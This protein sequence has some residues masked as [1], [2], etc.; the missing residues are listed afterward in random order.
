MRSRPNQRANERGAALLI[1]LLLVATMSF[2]A[3]AIS[4][5]TVLAATRSGN[6]RARGEILWIALGV[7][8]LA[9][10]ALIESAQ[11]E[12][13]MTPEH[14]LFAAPREIPF[15]GGGAVITFADRTRCFNV[16]AIGATN[17]EEDPG[18]QEFGALVD[19]I[20]N[21]PAGADRLG[22]AIRDWIDDDSLQEPGGAEDSYYA[23]LPAPYRTGG[24]PLGDVSEIRAIAGGELEIYA[25][26]RRFLCALPVRE[27]VKLNVNML[28]P[29]DAPLISAMTG[30]AVTAADAADVISQRPAGGYAAGGDFWA[31]PVF[32][33]NPLPAEVTGRA[34]ATSEYVEAYAVISVGDVAMN[35]SMLFQTGGGSARLVSRR[36]ER[37]E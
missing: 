25:A 33:A 6:V 5:R 21:L 9:R 8:E 28:T 13:A 12:G 26:L 2:I 34:A 19:A 29:E 17:A 24:V 31:A 20:D 15:D 23:G 16:N 27:P 30:G 10:A 35:V 37:F 7:E 1:V 14:P 4:E 22:A 36:F 32:T 11:G 18:E 3:L